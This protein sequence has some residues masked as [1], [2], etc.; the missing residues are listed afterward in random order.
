MIQPPDEGEETKE[1]RWGGVDGS[2]QGGEAQAKSAEVEVLTTEGA[3]EILRLRLEL[4][5][6]RRH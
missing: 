5:G 3:T 6:S 1:R 4:T 2:P